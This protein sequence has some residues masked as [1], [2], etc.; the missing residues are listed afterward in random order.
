MA[1]PE[2]ID[3]F[4]DGLLK[5]VHRQNPP[6]YDPCLDEADHTWQERQ[7]ILDSLKRRF[8]KAQTDTAKTSKHS[9][10]ISARNSAS[11]D[12]HNGCAFL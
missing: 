11:H 4:D 6:I 10:P 3:K 2:F 8:F 7:A 9:S 12:C 5:Q 1:L